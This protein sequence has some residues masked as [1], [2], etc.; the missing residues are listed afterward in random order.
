MHTV[1]FDL[2]VVDFV[3]LPRVRAR[4]ADLARI[5]EDSSALEAMGAAP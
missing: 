1:S 5:L 3:L 2:V 4:G